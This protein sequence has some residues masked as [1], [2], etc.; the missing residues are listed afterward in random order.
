MIAAVINTQIPFKPIYTGISTVP[1][2]IAMPM[3]NKTQPKS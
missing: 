1:A 2:P 3:H